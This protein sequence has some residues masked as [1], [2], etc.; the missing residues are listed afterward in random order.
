MLVSALAL[1]D[2]GLTIGGCLRWPGR[3]R[4]T[5]H[6]RAPPVLG[7]RT[8]RGPSTSPSCDTRSRI[9]RLPAVSEPACHQGSL[10]ASGCGKRQHTH[11]ARLIN[12]QFAG[13][14]QPRGRHGRSLVAHL[15]RQHHRLSEAVLV[16]PAYAPAVGCR[17]I[18]VS[19]PGEE[20]VSD[21]ERVDTRF[22]ARAVLALTAPAWLPV[23]ESS[24]VE[25]GTERHRDCRWFVNGAL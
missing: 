1:T 22:R 20:H 12:G 18:G 4:R 19:P 2:P 24:S 11:C 5:S 16:T 25:A 17:P 6:M 15:D 9:C 10:S 14:S 8:S 7:G 23:S 3:D 21:E 13:R